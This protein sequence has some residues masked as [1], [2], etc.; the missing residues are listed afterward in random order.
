MRTRGRIP[1]APPLVS[2]S[3]TPI[4]WVAF[5][6]G[7]SAHPVE[8]EG[9]DAGVNHI[10]KHG[11]DNGHYQEGLHGVVILIAYGAHVSHGV[12]RGAQPEAA[13]AGH[14]HRGIVVV[15]QQVE[16]HVIGKHYHHQ[17]LH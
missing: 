17:H 12:G 4:Q 8:K 15:S 5:F 10:D 11:T 2:N 13:D 16:R 9:N 3:L 14:E 7:P 1:P 6:L